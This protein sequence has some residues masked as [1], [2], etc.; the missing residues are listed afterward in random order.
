MTTAPSSA[1]SN[2]L[3]QGRLAL[4]VSLG[5]EWWLDALER[6][7]EL[8]QA[9]ALLHLA[10]CDTWLNQRAAARARS[11]QAVRL[12]R[13]QG[14]AA[15]EAAALSVLSH[16]ASLSGEHEEAVEAALLGVGLARASRDAGA[17][18][19]AQ[20]DLGQALMWARSHERAAEA[21][22]KAVDA[23]HACK[24]PR[25]PL[26]ACLALACNELM[27]LAEQRERLGAA[28]TLGMLDA[29]LLHARH[30]LDE[31]AEP[32]P[33]ELLQWQLMSALRRVWKGEAELA[34]REL[35]AL[36]PLRVRVGREHWMSLVVLVVQAEQAWLGG[37]PALALHHAEQV[38]VEADRLKHE[39]LAQ[40]GEALASRIEEAQGRSGE[41]LLR[42]RRLR[43]RE[44][45]VRVQRLDSRAEAVQWQL[46]ARRSAADRDLLA[47][48]AQRLEKLSMEDA[49]TGLANRRAFER[50]LQVLVEARPPPQACV[51]L[52]DVDHFKQINDGHSHLVG[53]R[54]LTQIAR[55]LREHVREHDLAA[56][57]AGDEFVLLLRGASEAVA[58]RA[59]ERLRDGVRR[60]DWTALA[61][62]LAVGISVGFAPLR[63]GDSVESL[64]ARSDAAM[65]A[66]KRSRDAVH[67]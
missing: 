67:P 19:L 6:A 59:C 8:Q 5:E 14:D 4:A 15:G 21:L 10:R 17:L 35:L 22:R 56:R 9:C 64:L 57:L 46:E 1:A 45:R 54:V 39:P 58:Q 27:R 20:Q 37:D 41:A 43:V 47:S 60:H 48:E 30:L 31:Q 49:L 52:I 53:D 26:R 61:P 18:A 50:Q 3:Q 34:R 2:A 55:L 12:F 23:C 13:Q 7:D 51:A 63:P 28:V 65:Y 11:E 66:A 42:L 38:V 25:H 16:S 44:A 33:A 36:A 40:L 24:P 29:H 32:D 62:G